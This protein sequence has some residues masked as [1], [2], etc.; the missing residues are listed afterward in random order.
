VLH[1]IN[2]EEIQGALLRVP[3]LIHSLDKRD[4]KFV[5]DAKAW[6][7]QAEQILTNNHIAV[8]AGIAA[9]RGVL[10]TA[11]QGA[12]PQGMIFAGRVTSRKIKIAAAADVIRK[13]EEMISKV[14]QADVA[15]VVEAERNLP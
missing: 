7:T 10:I 15:R 8:A 6:L 14:L 11:E 3:R 2:L 4:P 12:I 5:G 1:I 13:A 9:L